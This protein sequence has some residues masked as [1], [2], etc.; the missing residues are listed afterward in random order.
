MTYQGK[1]VNGVV[2][3]ENG[4]KLPEGTAVRVQPV[5]GKRAV[6]SRGPPDSASGR[7]RAGDQYRRGERPGT[8][9]GVWRAGTDVRAARRGPELPGRVGIAVPAARPHAPRWRESRFFGSVQL[10]GSSG[11]SFDHVAGD[12]GLRS[13]KR[14]CARR[15]CRRRARRAGRRS[16]HGAPPLPAG[17][18]ERLGAPTFAQIS[19]RTRA[20]VCAKLSMAWLSNTNVP[21]R[22]SM[23]PAG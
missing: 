10:A 17:A 11:V 16:S 23:P 19:P 9:R 21:G 20:T 22:S 1:V 3:L 14:R 4:A 7:S 13:R 5:D 18:Q 15:P 2:V 12:R 8:R 6:L